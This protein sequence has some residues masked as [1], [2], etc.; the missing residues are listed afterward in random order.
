MTDVGVDFFAEWG[1]GL[2]QR[3]L[4]RCRFLRLAVAVGS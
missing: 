1:G 2:F 3:M 4:L